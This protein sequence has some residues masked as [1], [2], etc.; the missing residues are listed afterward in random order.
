MAVFRET[1]SYLDHFNRAQALTTVPLQ[2]GWTLTD[3]S[4]AGAP[5]LLTSTENG[6]RLSLTL[7]NDTEVENLAA[8]HNDVLMFDLADIDYVRFVAQIGSALGA[9]TVVT[10]GVGNA[11]NDDEDAIGVSAW[12]KMEGS[13]SLTAI[14][15]ESDDGTN[16]VNDAATGETLGTTYKEFVID[17]TYG[18]ADLRYFID[19]ARVAESTTFD[20]S[21][22]TADQNVQPIFQVSKGSTAGTPTLHVARFEIQYTTAYGA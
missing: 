6:G 17:F 11:R 20:M 10:M 9:T 1:V 7:A 4:V 19:G 3:T 13:A 5:T 18:L 15:A 2:N 16:D 22:I 8:T 21:N 12:F 14:V